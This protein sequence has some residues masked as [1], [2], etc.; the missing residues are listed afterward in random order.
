MSTPPQARRLVIL[1]NSHAACLRQALPL[2]ADPPW[3]PCAGLRLDIF[4]LP[5]RMFARAVLE[6]HAEGPGPGLAWFRPAMADAASLAK[7]RE[8]NQAT[9]IDLPADQPILLVGERFR[10]F[11]LAVLLRECRI[12]GRPEEPAALLPISANFLADLL[13]AQAD[14]VAKALRN[15]FG[16]RP[17]WVMP[18]PFPSQALATPGLRALRRGPQAGALALAFD[19]AIAQA[20]AQRDIGYLPQPPQTLAGPFA[21]AARFAALRADGGRDPHHMDAAYGLICLRQVLDHL[22]PDAAQP[23]NLPPAPSP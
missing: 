11:H 22:R 18:A 6:P 4:A 17:L 15:R 12:L 5:G 7:A 13:C 10:L 3:G 1:G 19:Q 16:A 8:W 21:T 23:P 9:R 20:L 2:L 14:G